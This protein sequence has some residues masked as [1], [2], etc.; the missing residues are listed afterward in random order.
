MRLKYNFS[1]FM[2]K[3]RKERDLSHVEVTKLTG[4]S[5]TTLSSM[6]NSANGV[7]LENVESFLD[8]MKLTLEDFVKYLNEMSPRQRP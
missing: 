3:V 8:G 2:W 5:R 6:E 4:L 7:T 1:D